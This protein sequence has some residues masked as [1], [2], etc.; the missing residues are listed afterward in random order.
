MYFFEWVVW[1]EAIANKAQREER[2]E[3]DKRM[4]GEPDFTIDMVKAD[5]T[6]PSVSNNPRPFGPYYAY[7]ERFMEIRAGF[8]ESYRGVITVFTLFI[9]IGLVGLFVYKLFYL[10]DELINKEPYNIGELYFTLGYVILMLLGIS[11]FY[12]RYGRYF[13][14]FEVFT[15]RH[16]RV[17]FNRIT[18]QVHIQRPAYCGGNLTL[19]WD[20]VMC[21]VM[22]NGQP[23]PGEED[24]GGMGMP[25]ML[26]WHP[27]R[28]GLP[29]VVMVAIGQKM[30]SQQKLL[31]EW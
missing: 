22:S 31:D 29:F 28:T 30:I 3:F 6:Q 21:D 7:N 12:I 2:N 11:Y 27:Y 18:R 16:M 24:I 23:V 26:C 5:Y 25:N 1:R 20:D 13:S 4:G 8:M 10:L 9:L 17:R 14:R 15:L 19:R